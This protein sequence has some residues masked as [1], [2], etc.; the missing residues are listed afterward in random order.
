MRLEA[1]QRQRQFLGALRVFLAILQPMGE[2]FM[3]LTT[4]QQALF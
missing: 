4:S 3:A 1:Q 2:S